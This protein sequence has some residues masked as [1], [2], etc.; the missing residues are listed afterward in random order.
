MKNNTCKQ[1][2]T[3]FQS[4]RK[5][6]LC[7][8][9]R[10]KKL[11]NYFSEY[12]QRK[13]VDR[14]KYQRNYYERK[15]EE[16]QLY[17]AK[18][19]IKQRLIAFKY[20]DRITDINPDKIFFKVGNAV[21]EECEKSFP[22]KFEYKPTFRNNQIY[23]FCSTQYNTTPWGAY[24]CPECGLVQTTCID[25]YHYTIDYYYE[26]KP[27]PA[28]NEEIKEILKE[29]KRD[30]ERNLMRVKTHRYAKFFHGTNKIDFLSEAEVVRRMLYKIKNKKDYNEL[31]TQKEIDISLR[32]TFRQ[33]SPYPKDVD[34]EKE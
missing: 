18:Y 28:T 1:C 34:T 19:N 33:F 10:E 21:C 3:K 9:C 15:K 24:V 4:K 13:K 29:R 32:A 16:R 6:K 26:R 23:N 27:R 20:G 30:Y 14:L 7:N 2:G 25:N 8:E 12:Y 22:Y 17:Q 31:L 11:S 5:R